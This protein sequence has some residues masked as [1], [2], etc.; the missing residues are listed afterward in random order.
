MSKTREAQT[1]LEREYDAGDNAHTKR[2]RK[3]VQPKTIDL[4]INRILGFN[5]SASMIARNEASPIEMVGKMMWKLTVN[6]N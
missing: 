3:D 1:E 5:H 4:Q 2:H 6:A